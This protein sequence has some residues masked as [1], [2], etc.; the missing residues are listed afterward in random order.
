[1]TKPGQPQLWRKLVSGLVPRADHATLSPDGARLVVSST[2]ASA[3]DVM[4]A[5]TGNLIGTFATGAFP[6]Q[7]DY[8]ADGK[9]IY[10]GS[11][12]DV[13][14]SKE[15]DSAKGVRQLTVADASTLQV[16]K[17]YPFTRGIRPSVFTADGKTCTRTSRT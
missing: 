14:I 12:G 5:R 13:T 3:A 8:S 1:M 11:I 16:V 6:H 2:T 4:D 7:N 9:L 10:N 15:P 17:T